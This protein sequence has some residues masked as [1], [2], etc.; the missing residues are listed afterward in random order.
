M[1]NKITRL[2]V[3]IIILVLATITYKIAV[4]E[5]IIYCT[6]YQEI[7]DFAQ[8][9]VEKHW[10][11]T[12][13]QYFDEIIRRESNWDYKADNPHS[14]AYGLPQALTSLHKLPDDYKTNP[15][16]QVLWA[17]EYISDTYG[18]PQKS[19]EHHNAKNWY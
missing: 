7:K 4:A 15:Q 1:R 11:S 19:L 9:E 14:S 6:D 16:T 17:I 10:D 12:Q 3:F 8:C 13:W 5:N 2:I 18:N